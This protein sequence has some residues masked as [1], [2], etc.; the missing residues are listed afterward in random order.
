LCLPGQIPEEIGVDVR[1]LTI[2]DIV[3]VADLDMPEG[4]E[5]AL[6][7]GLTVLTVLPP[8]EVPEEA[9]LEEVM[10]PEVIGRGPEEGPE[11]ETEGEP[12]A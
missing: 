5:T 1:E 8:G 7:P 3:T 4:V 10:E 11:A 6:D 2:G 12:A 9:E